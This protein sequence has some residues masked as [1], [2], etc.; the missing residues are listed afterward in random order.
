MLYFVQMERKK[1]FIWKERTSGANAAIFGA[2]KKIRVK[3]LKILLNVF[4]IWK[5]F[6]IRI[7]N[8]KILLE[9]VLTRQY[10]F[11]KIKYFFSRNTPPI[12]SWIR[13]KLFS[14]SFQMRKIF[15]VRLRSNKVLWQ[16]EWDGHPRTF[17]HIFI[18]W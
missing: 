10:H 17:L 6:W 9:K 18:S 1:Q 11:S 5:Y 3:N 2:W 7:K 16:L 14:V 15:L 13:D 4:W 8:L 12:N